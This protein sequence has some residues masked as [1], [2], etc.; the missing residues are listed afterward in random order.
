MVNGFLYNHCCDECVSWTCGL[1]GGALPE[2]RRLGGGPLPLLAAP[3][4]LDVLRLYH[5][6][7]LLCLVFV[8]TVTISVKHMCIII[9]MIIMT[10]STLL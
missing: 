6:C 4:L 1:A 10:I 9:V 8:I 2:Q 7:S 3:G 5:L